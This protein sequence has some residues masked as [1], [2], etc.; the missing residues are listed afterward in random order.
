M[1][2]PDPVMT[3]EAVKGAAWEFRY[4]NEVKQAVRP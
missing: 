2:E 4:G 3:R 1:C